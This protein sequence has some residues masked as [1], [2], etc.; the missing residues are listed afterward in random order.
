MD[1]KLIEAIIHPLTA[2]FLA[3]EKLRHTSHF[4]FP[5]CLLAT[6]LAVLAAPAMAEGPAYDCR[7]ASGSIEKLICDDPALAALDRTLSPVYAAALNK[8]GNEDS[9]RL[10]TEQRGWIKG[11]NDCWKAD[12]RRACVIDEYRRRILEL[13]A[14]YQLVAKIATVRYVCDGNPPS[15]VTAT[16][17]ETDPPSLVA[18]RGDQTALMF[19]A[20]SASG[21]RYVGRNES[22]WEHQGEATIVWG[23]QAPE[24]RCRIEARESRFAPQ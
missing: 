11:R 17:F 13:Q 6:C 20:R 22:L 24:M 18:A 8:A 14:R 1:A 2:M 4:V 12:D 7:Q 16:Y 3:L 5:S 15:E 9:P 19:I 21:A 23:H 10:K